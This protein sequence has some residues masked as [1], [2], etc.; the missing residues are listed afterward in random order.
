MWLWILLI[1]LVVGGVATLVVVGSRVRS[2]QENEGDPLQDRLA[3]S[4]LAKG[5]ADFIG[6]A[7]MLWADPEWPR[8]ARAGQDA[9]IRK[10][11]SRCDA[12]MELVMRGAPAFCPHWPKEYRAARQDLFQ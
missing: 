7:R 4:I 2:R 3:E 6:L 9:A 10:C 8:K 12:C 5:Y 1:V 11:R